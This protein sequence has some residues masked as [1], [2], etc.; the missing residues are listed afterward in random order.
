MPKSKAESGGRNN[1]DY[2]LNF[3]DDKDHEDKAALKKRNRPI[4]A[5]NRIS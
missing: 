4:M 5:S 1:F 2:N 3:D